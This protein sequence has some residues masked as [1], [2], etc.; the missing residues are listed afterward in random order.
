MASSRLFAYV[1]AL[2]HSKQVSIMDEPEFEK[3]YVPFMVNRAFSYHEDSVLA[4]NL[5]NERPFL[6]KK[7]QATFLLNTLRSR[8]RFAKWLKSETDE[9]IQSLAEY[10]TCSYRHAKTLLPIHTAEQMKIVRAR[11]DKGGATKKKG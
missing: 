7:L 10:Y 8:K 4:A 6:D 11:L 5:M 3:D 9:D 1:D 2:S